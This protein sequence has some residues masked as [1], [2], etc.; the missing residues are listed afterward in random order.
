LVG[1]PHSTA[2]ARIAVFGDSHTAALIRAQRYSQRAQRYEHIRVHRYR[3]KKDG[4][5]VGDVTL[6]ALIRR[7]RDFSSDDFVFSA[8]GGNQYAIVSTV[9]PPV[10]YDVLASP[11][12]ELCNTDAQLIP[13][14]AIASFIESGIRESVASVLQQIRRSTEARMYHLV[15]PPPKRDNEF[16]AA[17]VEGYFAQKG[18]RDFGPTRPE[19]RLKCWKIQLKILTEVC[20]ELGIR[21][22]MPPAHTVT[23]DGYLDPR[24]YE[25][26]VTHANRRYG[27]AVLTQIAKISRSRV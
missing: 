12:D 20:D 18:L 23:E 5:V 10:D 16:I 13:V 21:L 6:P 3:K 22:V 27:E 24:F 1:R 8:V 25:K 19:L 2:G 9:R 17:H 7:I 15:P 14:R 26:D 11:T 4:K